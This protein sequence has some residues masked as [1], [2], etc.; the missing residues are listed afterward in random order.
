MADRS[1]IRSS[2]AT[3]QDR[4][5]LCWR[6]SVSDVAGLPA[7][8]PEMVV[9]KLLAKDPEQR[10]RSMK[11]VA[12]ALEAFH[13]VLR[14]SHSRTP[15]SVPVATPADDAPAP[16]KV[17]ELPPAPRS[18]WRSLPWLLAALVAGGAGTALMVVGDERPVIVNST[19]RS[20]LEAE[21]QQLATRL[22]NEVRAGHLRV[23]GIATTPMLRAAIETDAATLKDMAGEDFLFTPKRG[24]VLEVFQLKTETPVSLLR[25]PDAAAPLAPMTG[26]GT[27]LE[28]DGMTIV[29]S[30][31]TPVQ[32]QSGGVGGELVLSSMVDLTPLMTGV[33]KHATA[34]TLVGVGA[35]IVLSTGS[36]PGDAITVPVPLANELATTKLAIT[37]TIPPPT[38]GERRYVRERFIGWGLGAG[39]FVLYVVSLLRARTRR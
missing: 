3:E 28:S 37:A 17:V 35:P 21:A 32:K 5:R 20:G 2:A 29:V 24:E 8:L 39:L 16:A 27:R 34:A 18:R 9:T 1:K 15:L 6:Q 26:T 12:G 23:E 22:D 25:I 31:S 13:Q 19:S 30:V 36:S 10:Y 11:D 33:G 38:L 14:P 7:G 4:L